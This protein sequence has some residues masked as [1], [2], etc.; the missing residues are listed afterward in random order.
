MIR[1]MLLALGAGAIPCHSYPRPE[2][3][4]AVAPAHFLACIAAVEGT[5]G[6]LYGLSRE[7]WEQ[8]KMQGS[9]LCSPGLQEVCA[10]R[11]LN[12]LKNQI[13]GVH[14]R[15]DVYEL[16]VC[17]LRGFDGGMDVLEGDTNDAVARDYGRRVLNLYF[18]STFNPPSPPTL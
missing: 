3:V 1:A 9:Y 15:A 13:R 5:P 18:D 6:N 4:A 7:T 8:E 16:A 17:W 14:V 11:H 12:T 10:R 2:I